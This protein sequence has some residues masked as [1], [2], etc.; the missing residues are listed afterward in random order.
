[1]AVL[2]GEF[3]AVN[4]HLVVFDSIDKNIVK[5]AVLKVSGA[6]GPSGLE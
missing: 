5:S 1:M 2:Q 6:G 4:I 3:C